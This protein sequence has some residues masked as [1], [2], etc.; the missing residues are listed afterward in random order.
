MQNACLRA[1]VS[2]GDLETLKRNS[3]LNLMAA[4]SRR[5][6]ND[7]PEFP[8]RVLNVLLLESTFFRFAR[9]RQTLVQIQACVYSK[10]QRQDTPPNRSQ[11]LLEE[12]IRCYLRVIR[13][14]GSDARL[15]TK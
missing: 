13:S 5:Q 1:N 7:K 6:V 10:G 11:K 4:V 3:L 14:S 12:I 15:A 8:R 9:P 2:E